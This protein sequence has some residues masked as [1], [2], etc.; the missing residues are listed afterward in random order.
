ML[1]IYSAI[2]LILFIFFIV[3]PRINTVIMIMKQTLSDSMG[4]VF[5][6]NAVNG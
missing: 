4:Y 3:L 5:D 1:Y 6:F 2:L